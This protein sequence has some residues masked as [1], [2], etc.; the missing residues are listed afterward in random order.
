MATLNGKGPLSSLS[1]SSAEIIVGTSSTPNNIV[2][3]EISYN[4]SLRPIRLDRF[5]FVMDSSVTALAF[6][7]SQKL[8][9]GLSGSTIRVYDTVLFTYTLLYLNDKITCFLSINNGQYFAAGSDD[10]AKQI[11]IW[12][13]SFNKIQDLIVHNGRINSLTMWQNQSYLVSSSTDASIIIWK[14]ATTFTP[15]QTVI[16]DRRQTENIIEL[17]NGYLVSASDD[18]TLKIWNGTNIYQLKS[19][20]T[21]HSQSVFGLVEIPTLNQF[22]CSSKD[23]TII[24]WNTYSLTPHITL[25]GHLRSVISLELITNPQSIYLASGS[26][27]KTIIIWDLNNYKQK[28]TLRKAYRLC[29]CI[30]FL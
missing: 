3:W 28:T 24:I 18:F 10:E 1:L 12:D 21:G 17:K 7:T 15:I 30:E 20:L 16:Q 11:G 9:V 25:Y 5:S 4:T 23:R 29:E 2:I 6:P 26:C 27:D 22:A 13:S 14:A 19:N 8:A